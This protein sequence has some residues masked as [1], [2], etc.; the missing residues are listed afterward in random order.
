M[1]GPGGHYANL[2]I[3]EHGILCARMAVLF[4]MR[5]KVK[6]AIL[7][8]RFAGHGKAGKRRIHRRMR[9]PSILFAIVPKANT[10]FGVAKIIMHSAEDIIDRDGIPVPTLATI[11]KK[12]ICLYG[13]S[14]NFL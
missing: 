13:I 7:P 4:A 1:R 8:A 10:F 6:P 12:R 9:T 14:G 5:P 3:G 11:R 2:L